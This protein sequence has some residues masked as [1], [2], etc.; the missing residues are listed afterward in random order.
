[1]VTRDPDREDG[2]LPGVD[3]RLVSLQLLDHLNDATGAE[4]SVARA[5]VL[6]GEEETHELLRAHRLDRAP[7]LVAH[8]G[9]DAGQQVS[10]TETVL[11]VRSDAAREDRALPHQEGNC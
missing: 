11:A 9:V 1:M 5:D 2:R 7:G 3:G 10:R 4:Q 6:P 8:G